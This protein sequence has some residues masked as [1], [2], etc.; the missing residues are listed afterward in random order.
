MAFTQRQPAPGLL[1]HSDRGS[2]YTSDAYQAMLAAHGA[3][4]SMSRKGDCWDNA[5]AESFFA[6]PL[7]GSPLTRC[8]QKRGNPIPGLLAPA[9][10]VLKIRT[11]PVPRLTSAT[12][13]PASA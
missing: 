7:R 1:H 3:L 13:R 5:V 12:C 6:T 10:G 11:W 4:A 9:R 8:P 2:H